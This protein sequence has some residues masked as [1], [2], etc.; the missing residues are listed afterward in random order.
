MGVYFTQNSCKNRGECKMEKNTDL[1]I[2]KDF[3]K[4]AFNNLLV[5][6]I[7]VVGDIQAALTAT[8]SDI[9]I[10]DRFKPLEE[11][12]N[13]I[14]KEDLDKLKNLPDEKKLITQD[15]LQQLLKLYRKAALEQRRKYLAN[16]AL[17]VASLKCT[18]YE[19]N[20]FFVKILDNIPDISIE[21]LIK[22]DY[23]KGISN[24]EFEKLQEKYQT[25]VTKEEVIL[26]CM[27]N[28]MLQQ[29]DKTR[30][31]DIFENP[32]Y[33]QLISPLGEDFR[34]FLMDDE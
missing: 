9:K 21:T 23:K 13:K 24:E 18:D 3:R 7:P 17:N 25:K 8:I 12:L 14:K 29:V 34:K 20:S 33:V 27:N 19:Q 1:N 31:S 4:N 26:N 15:T 10:A 5:S 30:K 2:W 16:A 22:W 11:K 28:G 6:H 32:N